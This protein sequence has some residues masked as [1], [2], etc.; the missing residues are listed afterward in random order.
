MCEEIKDRKES[1][2]ENLNTI[3]DKEMIIYEHIR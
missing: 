3:E 2:K 1:I